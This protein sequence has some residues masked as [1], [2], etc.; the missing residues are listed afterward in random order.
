MQ[1]CKQYAKWY[2]LVAGMIWK[3]NGTVAIWTCGGDYETE[4]HI[5]WVASG[6]D[7]NMYYCNWYIGQLGRRFTKN[8]IEIWTKTPN[9]D[10]YWTDLNCY[11]SRSY[12]YCF[13]TGCYVSVFWHCWDLWTIHIMNIRQTFFYQYDSGEY[14]WWKCCKCRS[15]Q[16]CFRNGNDSF[17]INSITWRHSWSKYTTRQTVQTGVRFHSTCTIYEG[18]VRCHCVRRRHASMSW[19][20]GETIMSEFLHEM[21]RCFKSMTPGSQMHLLLCTVVAS[22]WPFRPWPIRQNR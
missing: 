15:V 13:L 1:K 22:A 21:E 9:G 7:V 12:V 4:Y 16:Y 20:Q 17:P 8:H 18:T 5:V 19:Q 2:L 14:I 11:S 3:R 6:C 10:I